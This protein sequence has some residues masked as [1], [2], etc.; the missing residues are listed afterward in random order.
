MRSYCP[1]LESIGPKTI[2]LRLVA[3]PIKTGSLTLDLTKFCPTRLGLNYRGLL[4]CG[5][6]LFSLI[7]IC[8]AGQPA[9]ARTKHKTTVSSSSSSSSKS[10]KSTKSTKSSKSRHSSTSASATASSGSRRHSTHSSRSAHSAGETETA[11]ARSHGRHGSR[12]A[13]SRGGS[14]SASSGRRGRHGHL[15]GKGGNGATAKA[16]DKEKSAKGEDKD[17][18]QLEAQAALEAQPR[19]RNYAL[20]ASAYSL[21]DQG[22]NERLKGNY[23]LSTDK[24][25][26]AVKLIDQASSIGRDG[27]PSTLAAMVFFELGQSA[28]ADGDLTLA[29]DSYVHAVKAKADYVEAYMHLVNVL[30]TA[31]K[32]RQAL[33]YLN[34]GLREVP[35]DPRLNAL[36]TQLGGFMGDERNTGFGNDMSEE[37]VGDTLSHGPAG[38]DSKTPKAQPQPK[39]PP[40]PETP[41]Q[42]EKMN[43]ALESAKEPK[44]MS[45][46]EG[47]EKGQSGQSGPDKT[48][49]DTTDSSP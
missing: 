47:N 16:S 2:N 34:D 32:V 10:A 3:G 23:G 35:H 27:R 25:T 33:N 42:P 31:G 38:K 11:S 8:L 9:Q 49:A 5:L 13:H 48:K 17:D 45:E 6:V 7:Y 22:V 21:Y 41:S 29:R 28:E 19:L 12:S 4:C 18:A 44:P 30:A 1:D 26:E 40:Q 37:P 24:L 14:L 20:L 36:L 39:A 46:K 15:S 43:E